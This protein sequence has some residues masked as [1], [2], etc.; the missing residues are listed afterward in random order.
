MWV[1][2]ADF[3]GLFAV[4]AAVGCGQR[5]FSVVHM[6]TATWASDL[7]RSIRLR[8][9]QSKG[10]NQTANGLQ[11][12]PQIESERRQH[13]GQDF[14]PQVIFVRQ[15]V[16]AALDHS[17]LVVEPFDKAERDLVFRPAVGGNAV[18]MPIVLPSSVRF[19]RRDRSVYFCPLM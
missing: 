11:G 7:A 5:F 3:D 15:A 16:G 9:S 6:S 13:A 14:E 2:L 17:D 12:A 8:C 19:S 10:R 4:V 18:P 1:V